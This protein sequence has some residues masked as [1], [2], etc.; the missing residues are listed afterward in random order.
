MHGLTCLVDKRVNFVFAFF[1]DLQVLALNAFS[2]KLDF[3]GM[4][5]GICKQQVNL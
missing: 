2:A 3:I 1:P 4:G 5:R